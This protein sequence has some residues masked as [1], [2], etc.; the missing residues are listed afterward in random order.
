M[1]TIILTLKDSNILK[2]LLQTKRESVLKMITDNDKQTAD[3]YKTQLE[4]IDS[5][6]TKIHQ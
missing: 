4:Y 2:T 5:L 6:I 3:Y 1:K